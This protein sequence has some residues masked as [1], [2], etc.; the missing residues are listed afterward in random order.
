MSSKNFGAESFGIS[1]LFPHLQRVKV[2]VLLCQ[3][4][5]FFSLF[6]VWLLRRGLLVLYWSTGD[7]PVMVLTFWEKDIFLPRLKWYL[8]CWCMLLLTLRPWGFLLKKDAVFCSML[9]FCM[10]WEDHMVLILSFINVLYHVDWFADV[11]PPLQARNKSYLVLVN[12]VFNVLMD[13][14]R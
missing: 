2:G 6:V 14:N 4:E 11:E 9:F 1:T 12:N 10:Y 5:W 8:W 3:F 13:S 7:I